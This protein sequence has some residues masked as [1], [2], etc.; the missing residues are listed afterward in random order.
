MIVMFESAV[1]PALRS[2]RTRVTLFLRCSRLLCTPTASINYPFPSFKDDKIL[3]GPLQIKI[4][5]DI[6]C[7]PTISNVWLGLTV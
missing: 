7:F 4:S 2:L 5:S 3:I 6:S 1:W